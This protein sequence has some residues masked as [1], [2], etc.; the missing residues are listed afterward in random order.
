M[1]GVEG[2]ARDV[3]LARHGLLVRVIIDLRVPRHVHLALVVLE[4]FAKDL[5]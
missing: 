4:E 5:R 1:V 3:A 2:F